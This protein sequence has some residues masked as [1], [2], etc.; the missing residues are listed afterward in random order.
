MSTERRTTFGLRGLALVLALGASA[1]A[2][3]LWSADLAHVADAAGRTGE[4][5]RVIEAEIDDAAANR[6]VARLLSQPLDADA[7]VRI[8]L[9]DNRG[10]RSRLL[11]LGVARGRLIEARTPANPRLE[12]EILP[13]RNSDIEIG[14]EY[15]ITSLLLVPAKTA[16]AR[17]DLDAARLEAA[18]EVVGLAQRVR[19][20]F[21]A[22]QAAH[23]QLAIAERTLDAFAAGHDAAVAMAD[24]GNLNALD[25]AAQTAAYE[26]ARVVVS[27][28]QL[29]LAERREKMQTLL[30][31]HGR[32]LQWEVVEELPALEADLPDETRLEAKAVGSNLD[33]EATRRRATAAAKRVD[34]ARLQGWMPDV[35]LDVHALYAGGD[36]GDPPWGVGGG[37]ALELPM[38]DRGRGEVVARKAELASVV[39]RREGTAI[40][41]RSAARRVRNQ[42]ASAH[43]R[44]RHYEDVILPAQREVTAQTLL[45]YNA[46]DASVF[47]VL[48]AR[49]D[50]LDAELSWVETLREYWTARATYD[51]LLAGRAV[52][53]DADAEIQTDTA[54]SS[55]AQEH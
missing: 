34:L 19:V 52:A 20:A 14:L 54:A 2:P 37:V 27:R 46:M 18:A 23:Q 22:L 47:A 44:A 7:A 15:E 25:R 48:Q 5:P 45:Q 3:A 17:A 29:R 21:Y 16:A 35:E 42:L 41:V 1:C 31:R 26:R 33:L 49:R 9:L 30:G 8:A 13:E 53:T 28:L 24:A 4:L 11:E 32:S 55:G 50:E 40:D 6:E 36:D 51:A 12:V 39:Q 10:L 43:A 38:F